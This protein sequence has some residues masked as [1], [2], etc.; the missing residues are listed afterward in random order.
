M[1]FAEFFTR[2]ARQVVPA[3]W[4]RGLLFLF[5]YRGPFIDVRIDEHALAASLQ[6]LQ[7]AALDLLDDGFVFLNA[8]ADWSDAGFADLAISVAGTGE[9][10][11]GERVTQALAELGLKERPVRADEPQGSRVAAGTCPFTG[12]R[13]SFAANDS[14][15]LLFALDVSAPA[16]LTDAQPA[17][18]AHGARAWLVTDSFGAYQSLVRRLQRLGWA[19]TVYATPDQARRQLEHMSPTMA[20]PSLVLGTESRSVTP[21]NLAP[22]RQ[23]LAP[24]AQIVLATSADS[25]LPAVELGVQRR[26]WPFSPAELH[27]MTRQASGVADAFSGETMPVPLAFEDRPSALVVD[28]NAVNLMVASGLLQLAGFEVRTASG[29][30]EAIARCRE[31]APVLVLMDV[32]MPGMDGLQTTRRLRALQQ[33]GVLPA[34]RIVAATADAVEVG[35]PA[36]MEAGMDGYLSKPL[37]LEGLQRE[38]LRL[39][40]GLKPATVK[41]TTF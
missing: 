37:T 18:S 28:D 5:D 25:T 38:V 41:H 15:G 24:S 21:Q 1:D 10:V 16:T 8:Q 40:P 19:T 29:G 7:L 12:C 22:L 9:R 26:P 30:E 39:L 13:V 4:R 17:P 14:D 23:L 33:A 3:A 20:R 11:S 34:F 32:H 35:S 31:Q 6:R 36:C 2:S 27:E